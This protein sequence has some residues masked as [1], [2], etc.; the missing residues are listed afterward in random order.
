MATIRLV[1]STY[2]VSNSTTLLVS[3]VS[4][5]YTNTD[6]DSYGTFTHNTKNTTTVLYAY[7]MGFNFNDI[8]SD[9][10]VT[11]FS[12]KIKASAVGHTT[13][14]STSYYMSLIQGTNHTKIGNTNASGRLSETITTFTFSNG[15]LT[16]D[17]IKGYGSNFGIIIPLRRAKNDT[18][19]VVSVYG[20]EIE[21]NYTT[22]YAAKKSY[23]NKNGTFKETVATHFNSGGSWLQKDIT[24]VFWKIGTAWTETT[25]ESMSGRT[26]FKMEI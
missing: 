9:A 21:V 25:T 18:Q 16:W 26:A 19:D 1:P 17:T 13:S 8:P 7:I 5:V 3:D 14:T 10:T 12:I 24:K 15:S 6:S 11:S 2:A 22:P 20:A 4:N 23:I